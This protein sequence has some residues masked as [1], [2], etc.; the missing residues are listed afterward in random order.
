MAGSFKNRRSTLILAILLG[1]AAWCLPLHAAPIDGDGV[2]PTGGP[3]GDK[4]GDPDVPTG[5]TRSANVGA[6]RAEPRSTVYRSVGDG[7]ASQQVPELTW[8]WRLRIVLRGLRAYT[9]RF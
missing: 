2:P 8:L 9:F 1:L 7:S 4:R 6:P 3:T 5:S